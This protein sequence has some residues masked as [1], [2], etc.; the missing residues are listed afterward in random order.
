MI[1]NNQTTLF[2]DEINKIISSNSNIKIC[3]NYFTFNAVFEII[4]KISEFKSIEILVQDANFNNQKE[5]FIH[6][7]SENETNSKLQTYYRLNKT[8]QQLNHNVEIRSGQTGGNSFIIIDDTVYNFAPHNFTEPTLG[9]IK[10]AKPYIIIEIADPTYTFSTIFNQ[11]W[12][13]SKNIKTE[14]I[15]L[16]HIASPLNSPELIYKYSIHKIFENKTTEDI[17]EDRLN[18]TGFKNSI[19]WNKLF[20]FQKDAVLGAIDKIEKYNGCII[21]DSV[22]LGKTFEA[23]A[24]IKYYELRND[25]VLVLAPKKLRE[26]W[27]GYT[28]NYKN[29]I[30]EKDRFNFDVLNHTDL[31]RTSGM[32]GD[33]NLETIHWSNYDLIVIDESHNFRNNNPSNKKVTRYEKL[34]NDVIK[35]G[36]KTKVLLLSATP[37][38]TKLN[39]LKNQV[40]FIT[41]TND[42]ALKDEGISSI[43]LTLNQAQRKFNNWV[44]KANPTR[45]DL[46]NQLDGDYFKL[47]DIFTISRSRK[48]IEKYYDIADIG[49][50]PERLKPISINSDF[51]SENKSFSITSIND[52]LE[53]LNLKFYSPMYF[54]LENKRKAYE[55]L[56]DTTTSRGTIFKQSDREESIITLMRVNLLKRLESSIYS[57]RLTLERL[58]SHTN[59][60]LEKLMNHKEYL[61]D[62]DVRDFDF[63]DDLLS[64]LVVGGKIKVL[65]QDLD[66]VKFKEFLESDRKIIEN[67]LIKCNIVTP[68]RDRK[69][70][71]LKNLIENKLENPINEVNK[72]IIV[73]SAFADTVK[74]LYD[75]CASDLK[76]RHNLS[77]ALVLGSDTNKTNLNGIKNDLQSIL[78]NFSP[79]SKS[80]K[81]IKPDATEEIDILFCTDSISE[82]QN[83]QDCDYLV[84]YD[85][86]WNPVRIIQRFGR[87]DRIGSS[88]KQI[89]LVNFYPN[90]ELDQY[91]D[92][93]QRVKGRMQILDISATGDDNVID[94]R[95]GQEKELDYRKK[96]LEKMK[97]SVVDLEDLEG[98]ISISDLTFNDFKVDA[99][100]ITEDEKKQFHY[101]TSGSFSVL[102]NNI[103]DLQKGVLFCLKD[104]ETKNFEDKL[105]INL[106]HPY[107]LVYISNEGDIKVPMRMGKKSLDLFKKLSFSQ[108]K[109]NEE[110][111]KEFN[112][113]TKSGKF[114][115]QYVE[116]LDLVKN[117]LIGEDQELQADSIFNPNGSL[118]S[119]SMNTDNF[120][121]ISYLIVN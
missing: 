30:L 59:H 112:L 69:L 34:I 80:R 104:L 6:D 5:L 82:G 114:M 1:I 77:S 48:H 39:D 3:T 62:I 81:D 107:S 10:D 26:N 15:E 103:L 70:L 109:I 96:Q 31:T 17:H 20:N 86:H 111:L 116:L 9:L 61:D 54:I 44:K 49:K 84:N 91:I 13:S 53:S 27:I 72:K 98:G 68:D 60:L 83:L 50:F 64:D 35:S 89:Q 63:D 85:I 88:N 42:Q 120:E 56:Y 75:Q 41:E 108:Y 66:L 113:K 45:E 101:I 12:N 73:F 97:E 33:I 16:Y 57:F 21:A 40:A 32:S 65:L 118:L 121:V 110:Q 90:L 74:Y 95:A 24:I 58:L 93:V 4:N 18:R 106:L 11:L 76:L 115:T 25:R 94:E 92:L 99:D 67:L 117:H 102:D 47:L 43:D 7:I 8:T 29:N 36:V 22:G 19:V 100:R 28:K 78:T 46:I 38:N 37:V 55:E 23:L 79:I 14:L 87:I 71:D 105:K 51:D 52:E 2:I 119:Q